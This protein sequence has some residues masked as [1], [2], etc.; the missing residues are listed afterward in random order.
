MKTGIP[1]ENLNVARVTRELL[2]LIMKQP[3]LERARLLT[4]LKPDV[5]EKTKSGA[6]L[7]VT[8]ALIDAVMKLTIK[9]RCRILGE[10]KA[11]SVSTMRK[12]SRIEFFSPIQYVI[13]DR[14]SHG[15]IRNISVSG[16]FLENPH[17]SGPELFP[18]QAVKMIFDHPHT[19]MHLK[20]QGKIIRITKAG[21]GIR[22][23]EKI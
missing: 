23:D 15:F 18:G 21:L 4:K 3:E 11:N 6:L 14:L 12:Y 22:F 1:G 9:E 7:N 20:I 5:R 19:K 10:L 16:L 13:D 17:Y 8:T 2:D